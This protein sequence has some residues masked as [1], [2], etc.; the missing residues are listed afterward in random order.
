LEAV[1]L[2]V[3]RA[4]V[5]AMRMLH[6]RGLVNLLGGNASAR[7]VLP[8]GT[9]FIYITP[10]G[11]VKPLMKAEDIAV[12][13]LDGTVHEGRPSSEYRLHL[14]VYRSRGDV[15]AVVHAHPTFTLIAASRGLELDT[16]ILG[17]EAEYYLGGCIARVPPLKPGSEEL[18]SETARAL[19]DCNVAVL[20][21][22]GVVAIGTSE[23]PVRA[24]YEAVDRIEVLEEIARA[25]ILSRLLQG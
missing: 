2:R 20:E 13:G 18:A 21:A 8:D 16:S 22:H 4:L 1:G 3:R 23:D 14:A 7:L 6:S 17:V 11:A 15:R 19:R 12:I 9:Q 24:V 25:T 5:E 10:S